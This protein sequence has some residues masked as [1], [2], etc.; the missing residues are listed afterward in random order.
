[1]KKRLLVGLLAGGLMAGMVPGIA[2]AEPAQFKVAITCYD[3]GG[4][5]MS[6]GMEGK[7]PV[8]MEYYHAR[9]DKDAPIDVMDGICQKPPREWYTND[10]YRWDDGEWVLIRSM[11]ITP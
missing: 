9:W 7:M 2:S 3:G 8:V 5:T 6:T 11:G 4:Q 10:W 1:M